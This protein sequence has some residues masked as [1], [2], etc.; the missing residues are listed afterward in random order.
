MPYGLGKLYSQYFQHVEVI[1]SRFNLYLLIHI[2]ILKRKQ[3]IAIIKDNN[4]YKI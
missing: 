1:K 3:V 4:I 2:F